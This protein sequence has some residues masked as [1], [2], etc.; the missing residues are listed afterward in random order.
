MVLL[1]T[2]LGLSASAGKK[3]LEIE[4]ILS[5]SMEIGGKTLSDSAVERYA[6]SINCISIVK[7]TD[8]TWSRHAS[9]VPRQSLCTRSRTFR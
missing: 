1:G 6:L 2:G 8:P 3:H 7:G 5:N 9:T 4:F